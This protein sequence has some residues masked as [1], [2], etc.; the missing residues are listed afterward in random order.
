[1]RKATINWNRYLDIAMNAYPKEAAGFIFTTGPYYSP[2][3]WHV[4]P[5]LSLPS[6][7]LV[8][9]AGTAPLP[10]A[11]GIHRIFPPGAS[12]GTGT[13]NR[14]KEGGATQAEPFQYCSW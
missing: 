12:R 13:G 14:P 11:G 4:F 6:Q 5:D 1:M 9:K 3:T 8:T 2:E 7:R 10:V